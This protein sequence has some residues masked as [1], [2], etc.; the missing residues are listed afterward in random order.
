M[1]HLKYG[2]IGRYSP[3]GGELIATF[4]TKEDL[5]SKFRTV[6][7]KI[8]GIF[9][10]SQKFSDLT[11]SAQPFYTEFNSLE[12]TSQRTHYSS[13][14]REPVCTE[15]LT[16]WLKLLPCRSKAGLASL[17]NPIKLYDLFYHSMSVE[18][19]RSQ[20]NSLSF[21]QQLLLVVELKEFKFSQIFGTPLIGPICPF[22]SQTKIQI[23]GFSD[24]S[25]FTP[26]PEEIGN[27]QVGFILKE[28]LNNKKDFNL[29]YSPKENTN[30]NGYNHN[31]IGNGNSNNGNDNNNNFNNNGINDENISKNQSIK[32]NRFLKESG[33]IRGGVITQITNLEKNDLHLTLYD[34]LPWFMRVY[35]HTLTIKS[36]FENKE[37]EITD[38]NLEREQDNESNLFANQASLLRIQTS[39]DHGRPSIFELALV[40]KPGETFQISVDYLKGFL[41]F[42]EHPF[43]GNRGFDIAPAIV[44]MHGKKQNLKKRIYYTDSLLLMLPTP[45]FTMPYNVMTITTTAFLIWYGSFLNNLTGRAGLKLKKKSK[46][47][48]II[49][50]DKF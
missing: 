36:N 23:E 22:S 47:K 15:N 25:S 45:D 7:R 29:H 1:Y 42:E 18:V 8:S 41:N 50:P 28:N 30:N 39:Q 9:G 16:P 4:E 11:I 5:E 49:K 10:T 24:Y 14:P 32:L 34:S 38:L 37:I 6:S 19:T 44:S 33:K 13:L 46:A 31:N 26:T 40:L 12:S 17:L 48:W 2:E 43:D 27:N 35:F 3:P 21:H 20:E